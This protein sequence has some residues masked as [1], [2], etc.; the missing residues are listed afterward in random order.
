MQGQSSSLMLARVL[1]RL[2]MFMAVFV[3]CH[4]WWAPSLFAQAGKPDVLYYRSWAIVF[5][6]DDYLM[7][8]KLEG[9][10]ADAQAVAKALRHVGFEEVIELY[11]KDAS[12]K[13]IRHILEDFLPRKVGRQDRLV[14]YFGGHSGMTKDLEGKDVGYIVPWDA[15]PGSAGRNVT[16]H[17]L[18]RFS[19]RIMSKHILFLL[20]TG[21]SGWEV[22]RP[23]QLSLE[24]RM[25]PENEEEKRAVQ[26]LTA[27]RQGEPTL[28]KDGQG[29]FVQSLITGLEGASDL[30]K[31]G[32]VLASELATY[33]TNQVQE[34]SH[35]TQHPQFARLDGDGDMIL[36]ERKATLGQTELEPETEEERKL[37]AQSLYNQAL[38]DLQNQK[39]VREALALLNKALT[40]DPTFGDAY[41]LK[42]FVLLDMLPNLEGALVAAL[43]GVHYAPENPDAH[44]T[45]GLVLQ[46]RQ[47][48][49]DAEQAF[50]HALKVRPSYSD[51]YL[52]LG[53]LYAQ[54]M[55]DQAKAVDAYTRYLQIGG[56]ENRAREYIS[57]A[58]QA[59]EG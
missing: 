47:E 5:G 38:T 15:L 17:E 11:D 43:Q 8:P 2:S 55:K 26:L 21:T 23:Q 30:D 4:G 16:L 59:G 56:D 9:S 50:L 37:A 45:L 46:R 1:I 12:S 57:N 36:R 34:G 44:Y 31:N 54:H 35:D 29:L 39:S 22:T 40:Y 24:G 18:K 27:G 42:S 20:N 33:V 41:V 51:V 52:S 28:R 32:A 49:A 7:A 19:H 6:I 3:L 53:D 10:I 48:Y 25:A 14:I 13:Q 58:R